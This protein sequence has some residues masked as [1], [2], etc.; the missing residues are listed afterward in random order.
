M[1][2]AVFADVHSN[3]YALQ[4]VLDH[5]AYQDVN[6]VYCA[7]DLVGY[8]PHPDEVI[9]LLRK[10][11]IPTVMGNYDDAIGNDRLICGC[12]YKDEKEMKL[13]ERSI[14]FTSRTTSKDNKAYLR[15]LPF[16]IRFTVQG[17][18]VTVVH[19]SPRR[20]NEYLYADTPEDVFKE[21]LAEVQAD[22]LVCGHTHLPYHRQIGDKHVVNVGS[23]GKPKQGNPNAVYAVLDFDQNR[24][25]VSFIEV[26]Y[27]V[28]ATAR[29]IER[30]PVLPNEFAEKIRLGTA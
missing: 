6:G 21:C 7:G 20:L 15:E 22:V 2:I 12:D 1:R 23:V 8:G 3:Y 16:E 27:D 9:D 17:R 28:E 24:L 13:A 14:E 30:D 5:I 4:A 26:P 18:R 10:T 29:L 19:G 25:G 11:K